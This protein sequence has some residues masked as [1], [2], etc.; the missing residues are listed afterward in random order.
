MVGGLTTQL[1]LREC[2]DGLKAADLVGQV[3][4]LK[5]ERE[6]RVPATHTL[7]GRL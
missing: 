2:F 3:E 7:D 1:V 6:G 4:G 5:D